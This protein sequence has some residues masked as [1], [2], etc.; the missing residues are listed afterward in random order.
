MCI[1]PSPCWANAFSISEPLVQHYLN[2]MAGRDWIITWFLYLTLP[3]IF[4]IANAYVE[5][6]IVRSCTVTYTTKDQYTK[7]H[8]TFVF[9]FAARTKYS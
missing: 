8:E 5:E 9:G 2:A 3:L 7:A 6:S 4:S 1:R